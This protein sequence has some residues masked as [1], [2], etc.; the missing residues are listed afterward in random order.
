MHLKLPSRPTLPPS[1]SLST[2]KGPY[3]TAETY[4]NKKCMLICNQVVLILLGTYKQLAHK[5]EFAIRN[6]LK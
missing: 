2:S 4:A 6:T 1:L 3:Q 5:K